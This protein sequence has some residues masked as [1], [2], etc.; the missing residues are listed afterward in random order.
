MLVL[1]RRSVYAGEINSERIIILSG[2]APVYDADFTTYSYG[3]VMGRDS[4]GYGSIG[5][6]QPQRPVPR[7]FPLFK[8]CEWLV[9]NRFVSKRRPPVIMY[10][11]LFTKFRGFPV[12]TELVSRLV[13]SKGRQARRDRSTS[14]QRPDGNT[15]DRSLGWRKSSQY[16]DG[17]GEWWRSSQHLDGDGVR[18]S[19]SGGGS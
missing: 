18:V 15:P 11:G 14:G 17:T 4:F 8:R 12:T 3:V 16:L 2:H 7:G 19:T 5:H 10:T 13:M 1:Y 9:F 6:H